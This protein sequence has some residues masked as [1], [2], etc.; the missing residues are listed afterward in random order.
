MWWQGSFMSKMAPVDDQPVEAGGGFHP[1]GDS[2]LPT[3][4]LRAECATD[5]T[6]HAAVVE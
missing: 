4:D 5:E 1:P 3:R 6:F 2:W